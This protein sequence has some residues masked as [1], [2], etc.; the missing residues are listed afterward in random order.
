MKSLIIFCLIVLLA[1]EVFSQQDNTSS[2]PN[3]ST[4]KFLGINPQL[5]LPDR[6]F[7][8]DLRF[9]LWHEQ[10]SML[11]EG[12][13]SNLWLRTELA[14]SSSGGFTQDD[15]IATENFST[16]LYERY[17]EN[18]KFNPLFYVIVMAQTAAVGYMAYKHIKK[19]GFF[20]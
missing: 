14:L 18:Q 12:Y 15:L 7:E 1:F 10:S 2:T 16:P 17:R 6:V 20:K 8:L 11:T 19:Y 4:H 9:K 13:E 3:D 5:N